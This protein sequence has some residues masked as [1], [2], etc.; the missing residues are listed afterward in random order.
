M[1]KRST[2]HGL[3]VQGER[4]TKRQKLSSDDAKLLCSSLETA[5]APAS[6]PNHEA[7][8]PVTT[9]IPTIHNNQ[10]S[11]SARSPSV[12][13]DEP[14]PSA[15]PPRKLPPSDDHLSDNQPAPST[16]NPK[17]IFRNLTI[18]INGSTFPL[19][20]DHRLKRLLAERG[21]RLSITLAR[22]I[23]THV[24]L[25]HPNASGGTGGAGGGLSGSKLQKEIANV[26]G[27]GVK[28][29]SAQWVLDCVAAGARVPEY[30]YAPV[31]LASARQGSVLGMF[32]AKGAGEDSKND[33]GSV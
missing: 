18:Y 26:A 23:V 25:G 15:Q 3:S 29:V 20:S 14:P 33:G 7:L 2:K 31:K 10:L 27:K 8:R 9:I 22:R 21:A 24:V 1:Q 28:F 32:G 4:T 11:H 16:E 17:Q 12:S 30:A 6:Q 19:V 13:S 5:R